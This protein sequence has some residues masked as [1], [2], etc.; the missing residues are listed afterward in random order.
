MLKTPYMTSEGKLVDPLTE[1]NIKIV[2]DECVI[3]SYYNTEGQSYAVANKCKF[4]PMD[5]LNYG[6]LTGDGA[7]NSIDVLTLQKWLLGNQNSKLS[8]WEYADFSKNGK[9][10]IADFCL[11]KSNLVK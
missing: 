7:Y 2:N 3:L 4:S 10:D 1:D 9:L 11:I 6:D 8:N 5:N